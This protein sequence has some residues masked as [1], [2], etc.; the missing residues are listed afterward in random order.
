[1][2]ITLPYVIET[3]VA[4][5]KWLELQQLRRML[6]G[7]GVTEVYLMEMATGC[8]AF[9]KGRSLPWE[10]WE[11]FFGGGEGMAYLS[12][13]MGVNGLG[14]SFCNPGASF[15]SVVSQA[16]PATLFSIVAALL[17]S[18]ARTQELSSRDA[19][20][21]STLLPT[22]KSCQSQWPP[23]ASSEPGKQGT[24][25][26]N[27]FL[28]TFFFFSGVGLSNYSVVYANTEGALGASSGALLLLGN[29][30]IF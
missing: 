2:K 4:F 19:C 8:L 27:S 5:L 23:G 28:F 18:M 16:L 22:P 1:M 21:L 14:M 17:L 30:F 6:L 15:C 11:Y 24:D 7:A 12:F 25:V 29:S 9:G 26:C 13:P 10:F 20:A 3:S